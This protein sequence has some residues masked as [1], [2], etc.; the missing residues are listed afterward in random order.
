MVDTEIVVFLGLNGLLA[1]AVLRLCMWLEDGT[2]RRCSE[3]KPKSV[4][5]DDLPF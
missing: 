1:F 4:L 3:R 5:D 2:E